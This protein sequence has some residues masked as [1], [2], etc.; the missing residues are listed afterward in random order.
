MCTSGSHVKGGL[1]PDFSSLKPFLTDPN[2]FM[3]LMYAL[4]MINSNDTTKFQDMYNLIHLDE[5]WF[6]LTGTDTQ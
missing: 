5:K 4:E 3:Q 1:K 6:Y 2:K